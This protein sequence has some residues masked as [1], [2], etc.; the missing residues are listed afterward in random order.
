[1]ATKQNYI[2]QFYRSKTAM[3]SKD[4]AIA[5][6]KAVVS[7]S[8][9][10]E[11]DPIQD[12]SPVAVRYTKANG[13]IGVVLGI[14]YADGKKVSIIDAD[15]DEQKANKLLP[16]L[17]TSIFAKNDGT[18]TYVNLN[19]VLKTVAKTDKT[20]E[21][22]QLVDKTDQTRVVAELD[23]SDFVKDGMLQTAELVKNPAGQ[24]AGTYIH[25]VWNADG[26]NKDM[27]IDVTSLIDTYNAGNGLAFDQAS[28]SFSVKVKD[29]DKILTVDANGVATTVLLRYSDADKKIQ[30]LGNGNAD[31]GQVNVSDLVVDG[32]LIK[33]AYLDQATKELVLVITKK[34]GTDTTIKIP[35]SDL[36]K[37]YTAGNGIAFK[38][39]DDGSNEVSVKLKGDKVLVVDA[40]GLVASVGL[41]YDTT[42]QLIKL[43]GTNGDEIA[44]IDASQFIVQGL[45][46]DVQLV[47]NP[48]GQPAGTYIKITWEVDGNTK[49]MFLDVSKLIQV[50]AAG[51]GI[52]I[53]NN[54]TISLKLDPATDKYLTLTDAGLKLAGIDDAIKNAV[55]TLQNNIVAGDGINV[56][57]GATKT[58]SAKI[59]T[60]AN[61]AVQ[62][63][64]DKGLYVS[65]VIDG[66]TFDVAAPASTYSVDATIVA[67]SN[68]NA[69]TILGENVTPKVNETIRD[70]SGK[71]Y[72]ITAVDATK[73]T[74][75]VDAGK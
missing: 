56:T 16:G 47:T 8:N 30:L 28:R 60:D 10:G 53:V 70:K 52:D 73:K 40:S 2:V 21:K 64:S 39:N 29:G 54:K 63:G 18:G 32:Q 35:V 44:S 33:D 27:F 14:A 20:P 57:A 74:F 4:E 12:G 46:K 61:N 38:A 45:I 6:L 24:P 11:S 13:E 59:S 22:I 68:N 43:T 26:G 3:A 75:T 5:K 67:S 42:A 15:A 58:V 36:F 69:F 72:T 48:D 23:A 17:G 71:T 1:M 62:I 37:A 66:G 25:L 9:F 65:T 41:V 55:D 50:Y 34:D 49:D 7:A 19:V 51:Q 31:L